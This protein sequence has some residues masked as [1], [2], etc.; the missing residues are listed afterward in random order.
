MSKRNYAII[1]FL[2][3][4][5]ICAA[6]GYFIFSGK[7][8]SAN[9]RE[10]SLRFG[11]CYMDL[12]NSYYRVLNNEISSVIEEN[13]DILMTRDSAMDQEKQNEQIRSLLNENI[14]GL[15][16]NPVDSEGVLPALR[17]AKE[18]GVF[19]IALDTDVADASLSDCTVMTDRFG[20]GEQMANYLMTQTDA[21]NV[22]LLVQKGVLAA[23]RSAEG[24]R[25]ALEKNENFVVTAVQECGGKMDWAMEALREVEDSG[26]EFDAVFAINDPA[27][28]GAV[29][30]LDRRG[31]EDAKLVMGVDGSPSGKAMIKSGKLLATLARFP[32][33]MG[34]YAAESMYALQRG[35][36]VEPEILLPVQLITKYTINAYD[37]DKW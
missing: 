34:Q 37:M 16:I 30:E 23:E 36:A 3:N 6:G 27:A 9:Q 2:L 7:D 20:G 24:F 8:F 5:C 32:A 25:H 35:E 26:C 22:A 29:A 1:I 10:N 28:L 33:E 11:A 19:V 12:N 13:G 4:L 15:F 31:T 14:K 21:A 18:Q 17:E